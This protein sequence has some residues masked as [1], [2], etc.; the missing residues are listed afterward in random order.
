MKLFLKGAK[1]GIY[2]FGELISTL[3][4]TALLFIAY[5]F[6]LGPTAIIAKIVGKRFLQTE[7]SGWLNIDE[8]ETA[9]GSF[10]RQF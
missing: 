6:V 1:E 10:Y 8:K 7:N 2:Y 9:E 4:N 5:V 3:F